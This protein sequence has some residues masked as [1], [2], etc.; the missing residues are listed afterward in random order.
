MNRL[1]LVCLESTYLLDSCINPDSFYFLV[2]LTTY[3][4]LAES[5]VAFRHD[6][7]MQSSKL[8]VRLGVLFATRLDD[9][10]CGDISE[11]C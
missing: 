11:M 3:L 10:T 5:F 4:F 8:A 1:A 9:F 7:A 6:A 2:L